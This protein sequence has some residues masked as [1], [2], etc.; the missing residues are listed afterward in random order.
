MCKQ[1]RRRRRRRGRRKVKLFQLF[2]VQIEREKKKKKG[3][4]GRKG[5][6]RKGIRARRENDTEITNKGE[7]T[8][9]LG[10]VKKEQCDSRSHLIFLY[11]W[12]LAHSVREMKFA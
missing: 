2:S 1:R 8:F 7:A 6:K 4:P 9:F 3:A 5:K 11:K 10:E 12:P